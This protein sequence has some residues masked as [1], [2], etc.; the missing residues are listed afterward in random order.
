MT[1]S[2][3]MRGIERD[4]GRLEGQISALES[5]IEQQNG[6][7]ASMRKDIRV[8]LDFTTQAS[9]SWRTLMAMGGFS[10]AVGALIAK[11]TPYIW[12]K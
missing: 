5:R 1:T 10:A 8:M 4:L 11:F 7:I 9:A 6:E 3:E 2:D 12:S